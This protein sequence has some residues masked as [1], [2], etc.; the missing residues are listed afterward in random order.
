MS[1][2]VQYLSV[3]INIEA[4]YTKVYIFLYIMENELKQICFN[5]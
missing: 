2:Y 4:V 3:Q 5:L 1:R